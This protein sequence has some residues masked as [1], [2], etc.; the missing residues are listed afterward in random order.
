MA[1]DSR[2]R[3]LSRRQFVQSA[4]IGVALA[5]GLTHPAGAQERISYGSGP[6]QVADLYAG[7]AGAPVLVW[8][9][10]GGW[11]LF[12]FG[13]ARPFA[14]ALQAANITVV[15]PSYTLGAP[16][17]ATRDLVQ[18]VALAEGLPGRGRLT[19]GGHS[20]GAHLAALVALRNRA[21]VDRLLLLSGVYDLPGTV[22]DGGLAA[23]LV[24]QAFGA[25]PAVWMTY[26]PL[27][28]VRA[29]APPTW[30]VQG[31]QDFDASAA[32]AADFATRLREAG[33]PVRWSL[34]PGVGHLDTPQGLLAQRDAVVEFLRGPE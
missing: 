21:S 10:G 27:S 16:E 34:L 29:D 3:A 18:A 28:Y 5:L 15:V 6:A 8:V 12:D 26:S 25:D 22:R 19:L 7:P 24:R 32:R 20:A 23:Q 11:I 31:A 1:A 17:A 9:T 30:V 33:A 14:S 13:I 2:G 4:G